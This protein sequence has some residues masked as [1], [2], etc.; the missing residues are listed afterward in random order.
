MAAFARFI[1]ISYS[2]AQTPMVILK[3][4]RVY[5]AEGDAPPTEVPPPS[6]RKYRSQR[7]SKV[8]ILGVSNLRPLSSCLLR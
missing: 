7:R 4:L 1:G 2:S 5:L 8:G 6:R 3:G